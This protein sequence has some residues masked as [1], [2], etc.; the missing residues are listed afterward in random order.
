MSR[1][2]KGKM[3]LQTQRSNQAQIVSINPDLVFS[4]LQEIR[5]TPK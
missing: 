3:K 5:G 2:A 1:E 4:L